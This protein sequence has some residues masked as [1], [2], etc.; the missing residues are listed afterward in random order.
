M[1]GTGQAARVARGRGSRDAGGDPPATLPAKVLRAWMLGGSGS[2]RPADNVLA[3][4]GRQV[5]SRSPC[6][7]GGTDLTEARDRRPLHLVYT[8]GLSARGPP[9]R[10]RGKKDSIGIAASAS[11]RQSPCPLL[12]PRWTSSPTAPSPASAQEA[13]KRRCYRSLHT[14]R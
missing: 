2:Q 1:S 5:S 13:D 7:S 11:W 14:N 12:S 4:R 10:Q 8:A 9:N 3:A 6:W